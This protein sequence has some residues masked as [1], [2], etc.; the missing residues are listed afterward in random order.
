VKRVALLR[1][2]LQHFG[3]HLHRQ[4]IS[5]LGDQIDLGVTLCKLIEKRSGRRPN[6]WAKALHNW[7]KG[8]ADPVAQPAVLRRI[9]NQHRP[10]D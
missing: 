2:N 6:A 9:R 8:L 5:E 10:S 3:D 4:Q 1:R 7:L